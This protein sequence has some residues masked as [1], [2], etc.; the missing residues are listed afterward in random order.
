MIRRKDCPGLVMGERW[1]V[2]EREESMLTA[3][4]LPS[5]IH[6]EAYDSPGTLSP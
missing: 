5:L 4:F 2:R 1:V 6:R 3:R